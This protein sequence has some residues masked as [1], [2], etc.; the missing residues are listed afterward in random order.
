[1]FKLSRATQIRGDEH[2]RDLAFDSVSF[3]EAC[4][5]PEDIPTLEKLIYWGNKMLSESGA[6]KLKEILQKIADADGELHVDEAKM[7]SRLR[8]ELIGGDPDAD[9]QEQAI[10]A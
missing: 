5:H 10:A 3:K 1:M 8:D 2:L 4:R 6:E 7:Q 9:G